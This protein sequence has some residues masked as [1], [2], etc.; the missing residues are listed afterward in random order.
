MYAL[1]PESCQTADI[2]ASPRRASQADITEPR[3]EPQGSFLY[4]RQTGLGGVPGISSF[5]P[6]IA[7][8]IRAPRTFFFDIAVGGGSRISGFPIGHCVALCD[9]RGV[10]KFHRAISDYRARKNFVL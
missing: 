1:G 8:T 4:W 5:W 7:L 2:P 6:L 3:P 10:Q 9:I